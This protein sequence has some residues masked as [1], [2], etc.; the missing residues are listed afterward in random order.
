M[1]L[2]DFAEEHVF[3]RRSA[4]AANG[5]TTPA[6]TPPSAPAVRPAACRWSPATGRSVHTHDLRVLRDMA[7]D[8]AVLGPADRRALTRRP[9]PD[10]EL[11]VLAE[12]TG[13]ADRPG[14]LGHL[15]QHCT[16]IPDSV[17]AEYAAD[18]RAI[19]EGATVAAKNQLRCKKCAGAAYP[20]HNAELW[21]AGRAVV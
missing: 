11:V 2:A 5:G 12:V 3:A 13:I 19:T 7:G 21:R 10:R 6:V 18:A 14:E 17:R 1:W 8:T 16:Q 9:P 20:P 15:A 4:R